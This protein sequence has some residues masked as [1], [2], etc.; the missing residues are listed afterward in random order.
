MY[1]DSIKLFAKTEK[2]LETLINTVRIYSEDIGMEYGID[3]SQ[4]K[5]YW[6]QE[7]QQNGNNQEMK[8]GRK[9]TLSSF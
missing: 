3:H 9:A 5:Q 4:Q 7:E 6:Q 8:M 1:M 2:E